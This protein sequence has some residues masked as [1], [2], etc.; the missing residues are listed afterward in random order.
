MEQD[1]QLR[2][3]LR[4]SAEVASAAFTD[5]VMKQVHQHSLHQKPY[6]PLVPPKAK[7]IFILVFTAL[8]AAI[9]ALCLLMGLLQLHIEEHLQN[10]T[11]PELNYNRV[12][13][14]L[15]LFWTL[16]TANALLQKRFRLK[17]HVV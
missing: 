8:I 12:I 13:V 2:E 7:K 17:K 14:S 9:T 5:A 11:L 16:F 1:K 6:L 10:I 3:I 4:N 15:L